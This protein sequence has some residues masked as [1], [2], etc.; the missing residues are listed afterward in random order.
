VIAAAAA[1]GVSRRGPACLTP[2]QANHGDMALRVEKAFGVKLDTL[3][4]EAHRRKPD[5]SSP[6]HLQGFFAVPEDMNF[7]FAQPGPAAVETG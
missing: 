2:K 5:S 7:K 4:A 1:L 3:T 6:K